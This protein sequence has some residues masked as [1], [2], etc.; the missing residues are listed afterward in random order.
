[1]TKKQKQT[2]VGCLLHDITNYPEHLRLIGL[3]VTRWSSLEGCLAL[4]F[5]E[6]LG[7]PENASAIYYALGNSKAQRDIVRSLAKKK[8]QNDKAGVEALDLIA[9]FASLSVTRGR[10][11]HGQWGTP[12]KGSGADPFVSVQTPAKEDEVWEH[13]F[14]VRE[15]QDTAD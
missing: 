6:L 11:V 3:I 14:T 12:A 2:V 4:T 8:L 15:L 7:S 5:W 9:R 1:M 10:I 13:I